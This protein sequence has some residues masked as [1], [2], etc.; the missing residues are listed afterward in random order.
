MKA[1]KLSASFTAIMGFLA[2]LSLVL[3]F[4]AL[5]DISHGE[6]DQTLEWQVAGICMIVSGI[7][8]VSVFVTLILLAKQ[9]G[10]MHNG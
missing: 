3:L 2:A 7:F 10:R 1:L 9:T 8:I 4:L 6:A 5:T